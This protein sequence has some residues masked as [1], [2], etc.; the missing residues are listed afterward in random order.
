[1]YCSQSH[2][3]YTVNSVFLWLRFSSSNEICISMNP[4]ETETLQ[5]SE[6]SIALN[7]SFISRETQVGKRKERIIP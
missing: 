1:M 5:S 2:T 4:F 7:C 6:P 3:S